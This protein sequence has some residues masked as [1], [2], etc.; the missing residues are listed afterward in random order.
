MRCW[1][2]PDPGAAR[3]STR[4][5]LMGYRKADPVPDATCREHGAG[6][7]GGGA[8]GRC[9]PSATPTPTRSTRPAT[10]PSRRHPVHHPHRR[11][12]GGCNGG[13]AVGAVDQH[14]DNRHPLA[15][16]RQPDP[17]ADA[18]QTGAH[19]DAGGGG[20][21]EQP[22]PRSRRAGASWS[23]A[24]PAK[25]MVLVEDAPEKEVHREK[26][27]DDRGGPRSRRRADRGHRSVVGSPVAAQRRPHW[28]HQ[29]A[30]PSL[31]RNDQRREPLITRKE[32]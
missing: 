23:R 14:G 27:N 21:P 12:G 8:G 32:R 10:T 20:L 7:G 2:F 9:A 5:R 16:E 11:S 3:S 13:Q 26:L 22:G 28:F 4:W 6:V 18:P 25:D 31:Y 1:A 15:R 29:L 30:G 24:A 17:P 19:G